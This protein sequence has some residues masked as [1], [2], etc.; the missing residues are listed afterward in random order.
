[1]NLDDLTARSDKMFHDYG[2]L[3]IKVF[4]VIVAMLLLGLYFLSTV[5]APSGNSVTDT[6]LT[7]Q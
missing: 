4:S 2:D 3:L 1:M 5:R 7:N 6:K